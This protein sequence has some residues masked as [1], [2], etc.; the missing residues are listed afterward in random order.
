MKPNSDQLYK[1]Y[2]AWK[3]AVDEIN[4]VEGLVPTFVM[5]VLPASALSVAKNN[6]VGNTWGLNDDQSY[7]CKLLE[8]DS[9]FQLLSTECRI[10]QLDPPLTYVFSVAILDQLEKC[11]GRPSDDQLG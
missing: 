10:L 6:G 5:N 7:I 1:I 9:S 3:T 11:C 8:L 2:Q 4:D